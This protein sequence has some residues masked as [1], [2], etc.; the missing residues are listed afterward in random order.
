M[1]EPIL[2]IQKRIEF[3]AARQNE[4]H[5]YVAYFAFTGPIHPDTRMILELSIAKQILQEK[6]LDIVDHHSLDGTL[7]DMARQLFE[8]AQTAFKGMNASLVRLTLVES[9]E[10]VIQLDKVNRD[11]IKI[12]NATHLTDFY[13]MV[14]VSFNAR[15]QISNS[16]VIGKCTRLHGHQFKLMLSLTRPVDDSLRDRLNATC[17]PLQHSLI[18]STAEDFLLSLYEKLKDIDWIELAL[19][20]TPNNMFLL[21]RPS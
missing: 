4:G 1:T 6:V 16:K 12:Q 19:Q 21:C 7:E 17:V 10:A 2:L 13:K 15:H 11:T 5:N 14:S 8:R 18:Q 3:S 9:E 20:E